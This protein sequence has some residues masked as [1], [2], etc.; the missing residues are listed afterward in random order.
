M[1]PRLWSSALTFGHQQVTLQDLEFSVRQLAEIA[2]RALSPGINDPFT[3]G[4]RP[5]TTGRRS[6][7]G[8]DPVSCPPAQFR[9]TA[10]SS[11]VRPVT[12]YD[13]LC[14]AMFHTIRQNAS[15][16]GFVLIRM[17]DVL[18]KVVQ[19]RAQDGPRRAR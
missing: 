2:V 17:L 16:S 1:P 5:R 15:N 9:E 10:R 12:D 6:L 11:I 7:S 8:C 14:D 4:H 13:G 18:T 19:G 3:A